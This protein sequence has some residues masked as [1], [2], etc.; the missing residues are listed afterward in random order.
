[1]FGQQ[2]ALVGGQGIRAEAGVWGFPTWLFPNTGAGRAPL[3]PLTPSPFA[4]P[5][6]HPPPLSSDRA[7]PV[8]ASIP[9]QNNCS[10]ISALARSLPLA[11]TPSW[12][13]SLPLI[14]VGSHPS[15]TLGGACLPVRERL[16]EGVC[17]SP[18]AARLRGDYAVTQLGYCSRRPS[19]PPVSHHQSQCRTC[20]TI[21]SI[22]PKD[23]ISNPLH[24]MHAPFIYVLV[25]ACPRTCG[26]QDGSGGRVNQVWGRWNGVWAGLAGPSGRH[27]GREGVA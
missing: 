13:G 25:R 6:P 4:N 11:H 16:A 20:R 3:R 24:S 10:P 12:L 1:M 15:Y 26:G 17:Q 18:G 22:P 21:L 7:L 14:L 2:R 23:L 19:A 5:L 27:K 8:N 9:V